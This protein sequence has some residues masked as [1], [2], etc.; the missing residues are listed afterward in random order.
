MRRSAGMSVLIP[1]VILLGAA[2]AFPSAA[3]AQ[4][5]PRDEYLRYVPLEVPRV[6]SATPASA[7][8]HLYGDPADPSYRD[9][10]PV[11]GMDDRR[12]A[13]FQ[14]LSV[15][16]APFLVQNTWAVPLDLKKFREDG[17]AGRL[18]VDTWNLMTRPN[19]LVTTEEVSFFPIA[20]VPC[21]GPVDTT[22]DIAPVEIERLRQGDCRV[23]QLMERGLGIGKGF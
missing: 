9:E 14:D 19:S 17:I 20:P 18:N 4:A 11:D 15:R 22:I 12:F 16:F 8:L 5:I 6:I 13:V 21:T 10:A 2:I 7:R 1:A 23:Q 3:V